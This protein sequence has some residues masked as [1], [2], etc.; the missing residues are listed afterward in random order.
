MTE[1]SD[2]QMCTLQLLAQE[3]LIY[4]I[5]G[6]SPS[7]DAEM[8]AED[9]WGTSNASYNAQH[10]LFTKADYV[11][12][13]SYYSSNVLTGYSDNQCIPFSA[14]KNWNWSALGNNVMNYTRNLNLNTYGVINVY[15]YNPDM[16][17]RT[18]ELTPSYM[19]GLTVTN[20]NGNK[21]YP[22]GVWQCPIG[23]PDTN[24]ILF[25]HTYLYG[26]SKKIYRPIS[27][28]YSTGWCHLFTV[29]W[30]HGGPLYPY[31]S[32]NLMFNETD[33]GRIGA[34]TMTI[35]GRCGGGRKFR[36]CTYTAVSV[37]QD[38]DTWRMY[39]IHDPVAIS[40]GSTANIYIYTD[41]L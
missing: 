3:D 20:W 31:I 6:G 10:R 8:A 30:G 38:G 34:S 18:W 7:N 21:D 15:Y 28:N 26:G 37:V 12:G 24:T 29:S 32:V 41:P 2:N 27:Y 5:S 40:N 33:Y 16:R 35:D 39:Q 4:Q 14:F 17:Y 9:I 25:N 11:R 13:N 22:Q 23:T 1:P 36:T 19:G